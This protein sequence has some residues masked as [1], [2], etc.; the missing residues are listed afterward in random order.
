MMYKPL[1]TPYNIEKYSILIKRNKNYAMEN[2]Y[3]TV[4]TIFHYET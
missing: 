3:L 2:I 1:E 4:N